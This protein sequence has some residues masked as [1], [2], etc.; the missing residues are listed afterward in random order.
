MGDERARVGRPVA[1]TPAIIEAL[2]ALEFFT[3]RTARKLGLR[4]P[5]LDSLCRRGD[6]ERVAHG[7]YRVAKAVRSSLSSSRA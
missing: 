3:P 2:R 1:V 6:V 5:S 7:V 4:Q